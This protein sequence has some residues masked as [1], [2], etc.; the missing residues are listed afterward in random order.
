MKIFMKIF[1][2][3]F[4]LVRGGGGARPAPRMKIFMKIFSY[5]FGLVRGGGG[6]RPAPRSKFFH[7]LW[8]GLDRGGEG[9]PPPLLVL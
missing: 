4:G 6:A 5:E 8:E 9:N 3:E 2:Y 7:N 1:S